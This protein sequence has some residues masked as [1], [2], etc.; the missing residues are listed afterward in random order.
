MTICL[1][2]LMF[3][4]LWLFGPLQN[5]EIY[6]TSGGST[7]VLA[8]RCRRV[9]L[10]FLLCSLRCPQANSL[11]WKTMTVTGTLPLGMPLR[12]KGGWSPV[13]GSRRLRYHCENGRGGR[14]Q[15]AGGD[16]SSWADRWESPPPHESPPNSCGGCGPTCC[17]LFVVLPGYAPGAVTRPHQYPWAATEKNVISIPESTDHVVLY[18]NAN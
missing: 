4:W 18:V 16:G 2:L 3:V 11:C 5:H 15:T 10:F 14:G 17:A 9:E 12:K 6:T 1:S 8:G 13:M 7:L